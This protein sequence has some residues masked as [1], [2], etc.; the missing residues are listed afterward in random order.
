MFNIKPAAPHLIFIT[1]RKPVPANSNLLP[2]AI[3]YTA[4]GAWCYKSAK[5]YTVSIHGI[6]SSSAVKAQAWHNSKAVQQRNY[7]AVQGKV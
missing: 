4:P 6:S 7:S 2:G 1:K 3:C 5:H